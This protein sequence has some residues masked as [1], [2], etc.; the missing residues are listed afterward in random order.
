MILTA[1]LH[2]PKGSHTG[3][4]APKATGAT[5]GRVEVGPVS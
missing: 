3:S 1:N 4:D 5:G 2:F